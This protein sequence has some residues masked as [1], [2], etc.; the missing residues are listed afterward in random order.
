MAACVATLSACASSPAA[1]P[2]IA[3]DP[4]V[5]TKTVRLYVCPEEVT[6]A[7]PAPVT[8]YTGPALDVPP[9]FLSWNS[10]HFRRESM[11]AARLDDARKRCP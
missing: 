5:E 1:K 7:T 6:A 4:I 8:P 2:A 9:E 10:D 11:L 3:Q